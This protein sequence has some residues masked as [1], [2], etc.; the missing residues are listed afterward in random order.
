MKKTSSPKQTETSS[1]NEAK[2]SLQQAKNDPSVKEAQKKEQQPASEEDL[3]GL[4]DN[5][6]SG[7]TGGDQRTSDKEDSY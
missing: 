3:S 6:E 1:Q 4:H 2:T 5:R 7:T